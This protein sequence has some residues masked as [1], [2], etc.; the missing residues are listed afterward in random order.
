MHYDDVQQ[1]TA[2][3]CRTI[4]V[5]RKPVIGQQVCQLYCDRVC[6]SVQPNTDVTGDDGGS[7]CSPQNVRE[8]CEE[9]GSVRQ[10]HNV[11]P[12]LHC[13]Q[14]ASKVAVIGAGRQP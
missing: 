4:N 2:I 12:Q 14:T 13:T 11:M 10:Q 7:G 3:V 1:L 8:L 6:Q 9:L 5:T